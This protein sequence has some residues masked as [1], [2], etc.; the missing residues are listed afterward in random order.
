[1]KRVF[2]SILAAFLLI[3]IGCDDKDKDIAVTGVSF[4]LTVLSI[5][6]GDTETLTATVMPDNATDKTVTW[7]S[8]D[9]EVATVSE[10]IVTAVAEG[11]ATIIVTTKDGNKMATCTVTVIDCSGYNYDKV[12]L[13]ET[14]IRSDGSI[15]RIFEYDNENRITRMLTYHEAG[16]EYESTFYYSGDDLIKIVSDDFYD[17]GSEYYF[18][19]DG[20]EV[21][22]T[23]SEDKITFAERYNRWPDEV[24]IIEWDLSSDGFNYGIN[25]SLSMSGRSYTVMNGNLTNYTRWVFSSM[26]AGT[27]NINYY[28]YKYDKN[29]SPF[30]NCKTPAWCLLYDFLELGSQNNVTEII[31]TYSGYWGYYQTT[32]KIKYVYNCAGYPTKR[33]ETI[34]GK[35]TDILEFKYK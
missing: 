22:L 17:M 20:Y 26:G 33:T 30:Y 27:Q 24:G 18:E 21:E 19:K 9:P 3:T 25:P 28:D 29:K 16:F 15:Y 13:L 1:M 6:Q 34:D 14:I 12:H 23:K 31:H 11:T 4:D 32:T 10:G 35:I 8:D 2:F 7:E 5:I